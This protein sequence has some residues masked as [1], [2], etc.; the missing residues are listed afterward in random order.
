[1]RVRLAAGLLFVVVCGVIGLPACGT[2]TPRQATSSSTPARYPLKG[3]IVSIDKPAKLVTVDHEAIPGL[4]AAMTMPYVVK[5]ERLLDTL[6][7]GDEVT[8]K[9]VTGSPYWLDDVAVTK[10]SAAPAGK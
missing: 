7:P 9:V 3:K 6:S 1:M 2:E 10:H 5:D 4:M 8:A